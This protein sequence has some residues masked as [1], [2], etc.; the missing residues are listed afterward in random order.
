MNKVNVLLLAGG[1]SFE[2]QVSLLSASSIER[3]I[4]REAFNLMRIGV[5]K[6]GRWFYYD[7]STAWIEN[8]GDAANVALAA[9][10]REVLVKIGGDREGTFLV[11]DIELAVDVVFCIIHGDNGEDGSMQGFLQ[12]CNIPFV[13]PRLLGSAVC[14]DKEVTKRLLR[15]ANI[16]VVPFEVLFAGYREQDLKSIVE[17]LGGYNLFVK[18][19]NLGSSVGV[20]RVT[21]Y[22]SLK[23][24]LDLAFKYDSKI[25]IESEVKGRELECAVYG[26]LNNLQASAIGE[27]IPHD[28]FYSY[29]AKYIDA[30]GA[31]LVAPAKI[32]QEIES[33]IKS[34][35][36]A[37][38]RELMIEGLSRVDFFLV[39]N[40]EGYKLYVNEVNTLPGFT[41]IS[42]YP[43]LWELSGLAYKD[44]ISGLI[45]QALSRPQ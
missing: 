10:G 41:S 32:S 31:A 29:E 7:E 33:E 34:I 39:E 12:L 14:M 30:D 8:S 21:D 45:N 1:Q 44:L 26:D 42:M 23:K 20:S 37:T 15:A 22:A 24:S 11:G 43:R 13:G 6:E 40:S 25:L 35:S 4:D 38:G 5:S 36:I 28:S 2:H 19:A 9:G 16:G 3:N 18:P 17:R 27:I